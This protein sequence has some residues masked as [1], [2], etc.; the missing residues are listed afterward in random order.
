MPQVR[1]DLRTVLPLAGLA[2]GTAL[3]VVGEAANGQEA[4]Q[5]VE[6]LHPDAVLMD[7]GMPVMDGWT[8]SRQIKAAHPSIQVIALTV[9]GDAET[10]EK[11]RQAGV[12]GFILKGEPVD[13]ILRAIGACLERRREWMG[14]G[15]APKNAENT[16]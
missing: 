14:R 6:A 3:E 15:R 16:S 13:E 10:R 4:I 12:D 1:Q 11:A 5:Q 9:H 7:L 8:A 2:C